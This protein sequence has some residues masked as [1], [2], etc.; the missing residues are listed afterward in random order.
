MWRRSAAEQAVHLERLDPVEA[1][2]SRGPLS[3]I[4]RSVMKKLYEKGHEGI[5]DTSDVR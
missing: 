1:Y 2:Q 3:L 4:N 5:C